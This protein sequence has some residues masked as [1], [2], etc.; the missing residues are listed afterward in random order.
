M[1]VHGAQWYSSHTYDITDVHD[2][3]VD[4]LRIT[5]SDAA[6]VERQVRQLSVP[7]VTAAAQQVLVALAES[8][9]VIGEADSGVESSQTLRNNAHLASR[10]LNELSA[11]GVND[12]A[13][14]SLDLATLRDAV[15]VIDD[16]S[17]RRTINKLLGRALRAHHPH[18]AALARAFA[19]TAHLVREPTTEPYDD[20]VADAIER[21]ARGVF[22]DAM[23]AQRAVL[24]DIG[25]D[26]VGRMWLQVPA[27]E[28]VTWAA[29]EHP[30]LCD[31]PPPT[32]SANRQTLV[33]WALLHPAV[34]GRTDGRQRMR[35][36]R[37]VAVDP[38]GRALHPGAAALTAALIIHCLA[39]DT[40]LNLSTMLRSDPADLIYSGDDHALLHTTKAR[41]HSEDRVP[42]RASSMFTTGGLFEALTGLTRFTR[43]YRTGQLAALGMTSKVANKLYVEHRADVAQCEILANHRIHQVWRSAEFDPHWPLADLSRD[44]C[45]LRFQALR[46]KAL[47]RSLQR[48]PDGDVEGHSRRTRLHYLAHVLPEHVQDDILAR[49]LA[50][51]VPVHQADHGPAKDLAA[52][53]QSDLLDMVVNVC[54][55]RR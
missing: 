17:A 5:Y 28:L 3:D 52:A 38:I 35:S 11:A 29:E 2:I 15:S 22:T 25:V 36:G 55:E 40:G 4:R 9:R 20:K 51:F 50:Q 34:F 31:A 12:F 27:Q 16:A 32:Y 13:E 41:N 1:I 24:A 45:G 10:V 37:L 23:R 26:V 54:N 8:L 42:V 44:E 30:E 6:H 48:D 14:A 46:S 7:V 21:A 49:A 47:H 43:H 53:K 39:E 33:A 18:G 19:N